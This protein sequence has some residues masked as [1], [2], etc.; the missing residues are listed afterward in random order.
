MSHESVSVIIPSWNGIDLL[1]TCLDSLRAQTYRHFDII[2]VDNA[3]SDETVSLIRQ[4]YPEVRLVALETNRG[5]TGAVNLGI[6]YINNKQP[7]KAREFLERALPLAK[8]EE[9]KAKIEEY[10]KLIKDM[11]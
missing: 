8:D 11:Q 6:A 7:D 3:S 2:I 5:F 4:D 1:P 9:L 10:L